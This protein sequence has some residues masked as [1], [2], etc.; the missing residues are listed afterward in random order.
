MHESYYRGVIAA[1]RRLTFHPLFMNR[2]ISA[3]CALSLVQQVA[4]SLPAQAQS[5]QF[6]LQQQ[7]NTQTFTT[8]ALANVTA[9]NAQATPN[10]AHVSGPT[11][12]A[13]RAGIALDVSKD[14]TIRDHVSAGPNVALM[15]VGG[16]GLITGLLIGGN[17]GGA[18]AIGGAIVGLYG[19]YKY[20]Q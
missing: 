19:L 17:G 12:A 14:T 7:T 20:L 5:A 8:A 18:I 16:A 3:A 10:V 15:V 4:V 13:S 6:A 1:P 9:Q 2:F 11:L